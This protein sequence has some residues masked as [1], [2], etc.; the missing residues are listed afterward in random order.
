ML[1]LGG[2][3][4]HRVYFWARNRLQI[5]RGVKLGAD[6]A[7]ELFRVVRHQIGN[8]NKINRWM[9]Q[10]LTCAYGADA[11]TADHGDAEL[12]AFDGVLPVLISAHSMRGDVDSTGGFAEWNVMRRQVTLA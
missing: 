8:A 5:I 12:L 9:G 4:N 2:R 6:T 1:A 10:R 7:S 11:A 3:Y